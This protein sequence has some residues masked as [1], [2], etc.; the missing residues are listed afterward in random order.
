[1]PLFTLDRAIG[2]PGTKSLQDVAYH[3]LKV[4]SQNM[5]ISFTANLQ[6]LDTPDLIDKNT[7]RWSF[8]DMTCFIQHDNLERKWV[9][10]DLRQATVI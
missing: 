10:D 7:L 4:F 1:M 9:C 3:S 8:D 5:G 2:V 6:P